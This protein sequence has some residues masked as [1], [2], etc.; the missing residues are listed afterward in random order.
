MPN[1]KFQTNPNDQ[2]SNFKQNRFGHSKLELGIYLGFVVWNLGFGLV[3]KTFP[4]LIH[5]QCLTGY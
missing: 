5:D 2:I 4:R 3:A 1:L